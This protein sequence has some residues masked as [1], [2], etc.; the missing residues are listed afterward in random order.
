MNSNYNKKLQGIDWSFSS[1]SNSGIHSIHWYP[2][3]YISAIPGTLIPSLTPHGSTILDPFCGSGT[4]GL[5][6]LRLGNNFIGIDTNPIALLMTE[7]KLYYPNP[8][9]FIKR[10]HEIVRD[11]QLH[12]STGDIEGHPQENELKC[13]YHPDT[14]AELNALLSQIIFISDKRSRRCALAVFSSM[15]KGLSSQG[16]HWGWVCDN[17][18]PK[19]G[20]ITYKNAFVSFLNAVDEYIASSKASFRI[21]KEISP[22]DTRQKVRKRFSLKQGDCVNHMEKLSINSVDLIM[23]SPPYY[24]VADYIK[25]QR[26]S[27]L[28]FDRDEL[29]SEN[30]GFRDFE[31]LRKQE[32]GSRSHRHR[33]NSRSIYLEFIGDF[34]KSSSRVLRPGGHIALVVGESKAREATTEALVESALLAGFELILRKERDIKSTRRRLMAKV[35]GEDVLI[36]Q[37]QKD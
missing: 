32:K 26:L 25:S 16:R 1:F 24:G 20:E 28:W 22:N 35:K 3:T 21:L 34:L 31:K 33:S 30:I 36:F 9:T 27:Y 18:K 8:V 10:A 37:N 13:W 6:S 23:T 2:A 11:S 14:V 5:E 12:F 15:L 29:A 4:S 7:A 19:P 17:V